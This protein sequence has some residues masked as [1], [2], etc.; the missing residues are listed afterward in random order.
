MKTTMKF[1]VKGNEVV[2]DFEGSLTEFI[3]INKEII[4][5]TKE[6]LDAIDERKEQAMTLL[7]YAVE[8]VGNSYKKFIVK[9]KE[10]K[11]FE[12]I[13]KNKK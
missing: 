11:D 9:E 5:S 12:N 3:G 6:T 8:R 13:I 7:D 2:I 4:R 1:N 10:V